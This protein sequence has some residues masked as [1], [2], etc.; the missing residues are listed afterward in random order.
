VGVASIILGT[1]A[2]LEGFEAGLEG[3]GVR[4]AS[5]VLG[6]SVSSRLGGCIVVPTRDE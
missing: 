3:D 6:T 2:S 4:V 1:S 5:V